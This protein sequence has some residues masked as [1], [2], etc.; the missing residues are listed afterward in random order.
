[1]LVEQLRTTRAELQRTI[2]ETHK[3]VADSNSVVRKAEK[4]DQ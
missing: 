1:M 4:T 2:D 3:A